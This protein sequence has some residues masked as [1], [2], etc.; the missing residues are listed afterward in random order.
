MRW[1]TTLLDLAG[2]TAIAVGVF[3]VAG[4]GSALVTGGVLVLVVSWRLSVSSEPRADG[5]GR[6]DRV[7]SR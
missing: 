7:A 2:L 6:G 5:G 4:L 1:V 3:L